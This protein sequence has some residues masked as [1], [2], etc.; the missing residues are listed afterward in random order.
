[1]LILFKVNEELIDPVIDPN[2]F[3]SFILINNLEHGNNI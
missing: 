2:E 3:I 1:M